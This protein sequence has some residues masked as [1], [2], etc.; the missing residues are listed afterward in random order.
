MTYKEYALRIADAKNYE[1]AES[2]IAD[3]GYPAD[4][5]FT[6]DGLVKAFKIIYAVSREDFNA[7][8]AETGLSIYAF[9]KMLDI[10]KQTAAHW[11]GGKRTPPSY[12]LSLIGYACISIF[13]EKD[14]T[15]Y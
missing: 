2:H 15:Q 5:P 11:A 7:I 6:G 13:C 4:C 14:D 8:V 3:Y 12:T 10:P 9:A 1:S